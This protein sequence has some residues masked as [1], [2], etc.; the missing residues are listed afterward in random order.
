MALSQELQAKLNVFN[1]KYGIEFDLENMENNYRKFAYIDNFMF[2]AKPEAQRE[3][4]IFFQMVKTMMLASF[5]ARTTLSA[6][7][8]NY[9]VGDFNIET[10]VN[11]MEELVS[12]RNL[13]YNEPRERKEY[14]GAKYSSLIAN[15]KKVAEPYNKTIYGIWATKV[16]NGKDDLSFYN[17]KE[18]TDP[19]T[20]RIQNGM[21]QQNYLRSDLAN[22]VY[23][24][25][26]MAMVRAQRTR[27]WKFWHPID[28]YREKQYLKDLTAKVEAYKATSH[29]PVKHVLDAC[30]SLLKNAYGKG[31]VK[32]KEVPVEKK[33]DK[34]IDDPHLKEELVPEI[35]AA[36]P[37]P[38]ASYKSIQ[39]TMLNTML[40]DISKEM[41]RQNRLYFDAI[42]DG[43]DQ[44]TAMK[45]LV[46]TMF[47]QV[48]N[49]IGML[50]YSEPQDALVATQLL[51]DVLLKKISPVAVDP[52]LAKYAEGY[53][54]NNAKSFAKY[55]NYAKDS[56]EMVDAMNEYNK[57]A[58][59][60]E[61][62]NEQSVNNQV[63]N[64]QVN[65]E[66]PSVNNVP[67]NKVPENNLPVKPVRDLKDPEFINN[68]IE[69]MIE[70]L[71]D[72]K[73]NYEY[74]NKV[75]IKRNFSRIEKKYYEK[76][77]ETIET[78]N[79]EY[80]DGVQAGIDAN[81]LMKEYMDKLSPKITKLFNYTGWGSREEAVNLATIQLMT[82]YVMKN[83]S[84]AAKNPEQWK[85]FAEGYY[86]KD[87][88]AFKD[89][90]KYLFTVWM[91]KEKAPKL[92]EEYKEKKAM[93]E[94]D[95]T[96][97][98][99][100]PVLNDNM[101][102]ADQVKTLT[103]AP[104]FEEKL[105]NDLVKI[106]PD[107]KFKIKG[108]NEEQVRKE[109]TFGDSRFIKEFSEDIAY[110]NERFDEG[111]QKNEDLKELQKNYIYRLKS[112]VTNLLGG[113]EGGGGMETDARK[114]LVFDYLL[115]RYTPAAAAPE[116]WK[117]VI[118]GYH[119]QYGYSDYRSRKWDIEEIEQEKRYEQQRQA[120]ANAN[121]K[122]QAPEVESIVIEE[123][124]VK[125][126]APVSQPV[127]APA[128]NNQVEIVNK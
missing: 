118:E 111:R 74:K 68:F 95:V 23:A 14:A 56:K 16:L 64:A 3:A 32:E 46:G 94:P 44:E 35:I 78:A 1:A 83:Y 33:L 91:S 19:A 55:T 106:V 28:N 125:P 92:Y 122:E 85:D 69:D 115:K 65:N 37:E 86:L 29:L 30:E 24:R 120:K 103:S 102:I 70:E 99:N 42:A 88:E 21:E 22:V 109:L 105:L 123:L 117:D 12:E 4:D 61:K 101:P 77:I 108:K 47:D 121:A 73:G 107:K 93:A 38:A 119:Y 76:L 11:E 45:E 63:N 6:T 75:D 112:V 10:F 79:Q 18:L 71:P 81:Q 50:G 41:S 7:N 72:E 31:V 40:D 49:M 48:N 36:L 62:E 84:P 96:E 97:P 60:G 8:S 2:N 128:P 17:L 13:E 67:E 116:Q 59:K 20:E 127:V 126:D 114:Q 98:E 66:Q 5:E 27:W 15:V 57:K 26:A 53:V 39:G 113:F 54:L 52:E 25:E 89:T 58:S 124:N 34:I 90:S 80:A 9:T 104:G 87:L 82:D 110:C 100:L 51:L 43:V